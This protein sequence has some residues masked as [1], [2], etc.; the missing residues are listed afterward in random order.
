MA[1][2]SNLEH[3]NGKTRHHEGLAGK[4]IAVF[5]GAYNYI[6]DGVTLTLNRLVSYLERHGAEALIFSP[7]TKNPPPIKHAGTLVSVPSIPFPGRADYRLAVGLPRKARARLKAF[8]PDLIHIATPDYMGSKAL[9]WARGQGVPVVTSFHTHFGAYM[10][11]FVSYH[12]Y[13]RMDLLEST[14]WR[15]G[16][17]FYPQCEHIY[18][19][20]RSIA[21]ELRSHGITNGLRLWPRGVDTAFFN[22]SNR[23][24]VWRQ[25]LGIEDDEVVIAFISRLVWEKG[26][27]V[28]ADVIE[29]LE[30]RGLRHRSMIVGAGPARAKLE[31][32][33]PNAIFTGHLRGEALARAYAS[34]D[35]FLFPSDTETFGNV[36]LEAM[37][38]GVPTVCADASGSNALV[39]D[40]ETGF[41]A[42]PNDAVAFLDAVE[43]LVTDSTLRREMGRRALARA[44]TYEW[45]EAMARIAGYYEEVLVPQTVADTVEGDGHPT[46]DLG[47]SPPVLIPPSSV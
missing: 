2:I 31:A 18:V 26:L 16:R 17:W 13:Y 38:S 35:I 34:A 27:H 40:G 1:G 7:T 14:A 46:S 42:P 44:R 21:D 8:D 25:T 9:L 45:E 33:L 6:S 32:R 47:V 20:T 4:R 30:K 11:Y 36:T 29:G 10:K 3:L 41:L 28:F 19:P 12:K 37:A 23:S 22:P 5:T 39:V 43:R 24:T 15:Y